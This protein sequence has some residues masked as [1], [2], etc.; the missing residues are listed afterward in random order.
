MQQHRLFLPCPLKEGEHVPL[1]EEAYH[2]V[3]HVLRHKINHT[4][5]VFDGLTGEYQAKIHSMHKKRAV[6]SIENLIRPQEN[7]VPLALYIPPLRPSRMG[8]LFEKI[9]ELGV[10]DIYPVHT[11]HTVH[12][13]G[14][15]VKLKRHLVEAAEQCERL[16]IPV[17]HEPITLEPLIE[18]LDAPLAWAYEHSTPNRAASLLKARRLLIGPEGGFAPHEVDLLRSNQH[19]QEISLSPQILRAETAAMAGV[20]LLNYEKKGD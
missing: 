1:E 7:L 3:C 5:K 11:Q 16:C 19:V 9:T 20:F 15:T 10:T 18:K 14:S 6:L 4:L 12:R 8:M 2:Y 17:L 13:L